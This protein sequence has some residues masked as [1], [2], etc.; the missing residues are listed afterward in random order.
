VFQGERNSCRTL[1]RANRQKSPRSP[2]ICARWASRQDRVAAYTHN[3]P[4]AVIGM[5]A[6]PASARFGLLLA[7]FGARGVLERFGQIEP[8]VLIV[9]DGYYYKAKNRAAGQCARDRW[10]IVKPQR[11]SHHSY[12]DAAEPLEGSPARACGRGRSKATQARG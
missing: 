3:G 1:S 5:L 6:R 11:D 9:S 2:R 8:K 12:I 7:D 4:E 10:R